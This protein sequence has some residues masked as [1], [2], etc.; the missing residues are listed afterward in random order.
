MR[1]KIAAGNW[2]MYKKFED[3]IDLASNFAN[4]SIPENV[5]VILGVPHVYLKSVFAI[6]NA[7]ANISV[8]AQNCHQFNEGAFTGETSPMMLAS[9]EIPYVILGHSERREY[10]NETPELLK[11]KV[12]AALANGLKVIFCVGEPLDVRKQ[13]NEENFVREQLRISL[14]E[15]DNTQMGKIVIA[16][17]PIWAIGTG[18]TATAE[19]AQAMHKMIREY[20]GEIFGK[21]IA[22]STSILYGG[23][24][25][26]SNAKEL[27]G[28]E[29]VDGGLVG[30]ASLEFDSFYQIIKSF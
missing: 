3:A 6:T 12:N 5:R 2:K 23:S 7:N 30:G 14:S 4:S 10:F 21:D 9:M 17:E 29:D 13:G 22:Q 1:Q 16:Y 19:Q 15:L 8:S 11:E 27:F 26:P 20:L 18:E 25:K 28:Q 24:V